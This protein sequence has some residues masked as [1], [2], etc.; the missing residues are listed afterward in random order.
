MP[1]KIA[2]KIKTN[3]TTDPKWLSKL[4]EKTPELAAA[5]DY[6]VDIQMLIDNMNRSVSERIKRH[7]IALDTFQKLRSAKKIKK[8]SKS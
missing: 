8:S 3:K 2:H 7:Q 1:R 6:G 4:I 5:R